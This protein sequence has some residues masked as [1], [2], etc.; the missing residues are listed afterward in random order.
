M[1]TESEPCV[2]GLEDGDKG[3]SEK[4]T[5]TTHEHTDLQ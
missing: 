2:S 1:Y 3:T 5:Q 4:Y